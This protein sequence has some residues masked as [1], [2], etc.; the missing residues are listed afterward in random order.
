[1]T[2]EPPLLV[3]AVNAMLA[4]ASP[5]VAAPIVGAEGGPTGVTFTFPDAGPAPPARFDARTLHAYATP[6]VMPVTVM[7]LV[8]LLD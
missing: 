8:V 1:M 2:A 7:G 3:G 5:A 4:C 6:F